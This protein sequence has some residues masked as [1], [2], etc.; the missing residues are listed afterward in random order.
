MEA[1]AEAEDFAVDRVVI[2]AEGL[3][4]RCRAAAG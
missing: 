4:A 3:C 1:C 2:E